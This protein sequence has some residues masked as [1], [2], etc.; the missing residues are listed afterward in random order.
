M[1]RTKGARKSKQNQQAEEECDLL[2]R[3]FKRRAQ[4]QILKMEADSKMTIRSFETFIDVTVSRIPAE[5]RQMTLG[6]ILSYE[7]DDQKENCT[8]VSSSVDDCSLQPPSKVATEK[9]TTK[10]ITTASDDGYVTEGVTRSSR[11]SKTI[12]DV[13]SSRNF[14]RTR[15]TSRNRKINLSVVNQET[16]KKTR[17]E[18]GKESMKADKFKTPALLRPD[19]NEF[20]LVTPKVKPNTPLNILRRPRQGEMVLSMQGSPL[21]VTSIVQENFANVNVPL[22]NGNVISLLPKDGLLRMSTIPALDTET[23]RQL[24]TL[25]SH[26]EKV[27]STK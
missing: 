20:G 8:E 14:R 9:K 26:I 22:S 12:K 25:K 24:E 1:P 13:E 17:K 15:S 3:D 27:I 6:E 7:A 5:I 11:A 18:R 21:L 19:N 4:L 10:R 23:M 16:V 2:V